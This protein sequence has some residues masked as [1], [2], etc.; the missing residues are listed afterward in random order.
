MN[1]ILAILLTLFLMP[2]C[3]K[4]NVEPDPRADLDLPDDVTFTHLPTEL[5]KMKEFAA[6]GQI[7]FIPKAH[8]GFGVKDFNFSE[9][10]IPVYAMADGVIHNIRYETKIQEFFK[11][12]DS[13]IGTE[14]DDLTLHIYLSKTEEMHYGHLGKLAPEILE[15]APNLVKGSTENRVSIPIKMGQ[16]VAY[17]GVHPG[18]DIGY[19]DTKSEPYFAN[20]DRYDASYRSAK[21]F[22]DNLLPGLRDEIWKINPR[23]VEPR[24]GKINYDEEGAI[25]GNWFLEGYVADYDDWSNQLIIAYHER[26]ADRIT[27]SDASPTLYGPQN[28]S[29]RRTS[30]W[31]IIGNTPAPEEVSQSTGLTKYN[32]TAPYNISATNNPDS[33]G[34]VLI[35]MIAVDRL[36]FEFVEGK[37]PDEVEGFS[38]N[39]KVYER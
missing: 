36:K 24:G 19:I 8:C 21:P 25:S 34:T 16:I 30:L 35:E 26:W 9:P 14:Y 4:N 12:P 13:L 6:V 5:D 31:W 27:I 15:Q 33:E 17:I 11:A 3:E 2:G 7:L 22:T 38:E 28:P 32:V 18:F 10:D 37:L 39:A 29:E 1:R 20:P 23:T